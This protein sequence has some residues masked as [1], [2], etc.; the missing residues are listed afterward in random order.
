M[1]FAPRLRWW[2][3]LAVVVPVLLLLGMAALALQAEPTVVSPQDV[4]HDDVA[5]ALSLLRTHDPRQAQPGVVSS[6][7]VRQRDVDVLLSH[8]LTAGSPLPPVPTCSAGEPRCRS[9]C[10]RRPI[11]FP[12]P[13]GAG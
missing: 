11:P 6:A 8:G 7:L 13:S 9:A 4:S 2:I 1:G 5:R 10:K 3:A 12:L